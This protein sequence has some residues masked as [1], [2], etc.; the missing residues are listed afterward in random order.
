[1]PEMTQLTGSTSRPA[2]KGV[3]G[4]RMPQPVTGAPLPARAVGAM[5]IGLP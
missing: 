1:M 3:V 2:G 5:V 4:T